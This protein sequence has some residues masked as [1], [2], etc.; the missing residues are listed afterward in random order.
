[1]KIETKYW[2]WACGDGCCYNWGTALI[3]DG[4]HVD[5]EFMNKSDAFQ[6]VLET[7]LGH[8][9]DELYEDEDEN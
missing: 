1:M 5:Q 7:V 9:V 3:I 4:K 2:S 8:T 6:Y